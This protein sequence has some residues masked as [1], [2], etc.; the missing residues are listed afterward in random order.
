MAAK[1]EA[2]LISD[3]AASILSGG[4]R[5]TAANVR[6]L[7]ADVLD[8][9]ANI[10]DGGNVYQTE[11]GYT[12]D[13]A[14]SGQ[15]SFVHKK[16]VEDNFVPLGGIG[17]LAQT[18]AVGNT[19]GGSDIIVSAADKIRDASN[20]VLLD[21]PNGSFT[22]TDGAS[23][24]QGLY[25]DLSGG[26]VE[27]N[28]INIGV[29]QLQ[30][31]YFNAT[32]SYAKLGAYDQSTSEVSITT[33]TTTASVYSTHGSFAGL[34]YSSDYSANYSNR[35]LVDKAY[36]TGGF[37]P[38]DSDLTSWAGVTRASGFDTFVATPSSANLLAL[39]TDE[40]G[41]GSLVFGT[42][43]T[44]TQW[45]TVPRIYGG[46]GVN[47]GI[48]FYS[49]TGNGISGSIAHRFRGG[50]NGAVTI[51]EMYNNGNL[52]IQNNRVI[53]GLDSGGTERSLFTWS[54]GDNITITGRPG[55][56][57]I[58]LNPTSGGLGLYVKS[59][60]DG[61]IGTASPSARWHIIKTQEQLRV[62]YDTSNYL[63]N[64]I[65]S[66]GVLTMAMVGTDPSI[67]ILNNT[68]HKLSFWNA[69]P[70]VQPTTAVAAATFVANTS[71][72]ILYNES[73]FD[74]YTIAQAIK[75]LRNVGLLA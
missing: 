37:Q 25:F 7:L 29:I 52:R 33:T 73:T 35:S 12:S 28:A 34:E 10:V 54:S 3:I 65:S 30:K 70:I 45:I 9:Y 18:L 55:V 48:D 44:F 51:L 74:G 20:S 41:S 72:N 42:Q 60:G 56:S 1:N 53:Y 61:G 5:T 2:T 32:N 57:D 31:G 16:W 21:I 14:I 19:T 50:N 17:S 24:S 59:G 66:T 64:T 75:A 15:Y 39:V 6:A 63:S 4:R 26:G 27:L 49:T 36:V 62:G 68:A 58:N 67:K 38:L 43:P 40:T 13:L 46:T 47:D 23:V 8:S 71:A 69:A 11:V 22:G